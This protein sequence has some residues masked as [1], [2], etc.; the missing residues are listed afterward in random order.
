MLINYDHQLQLPITSV[1][2][3]RSDLPGRQTVPPCPWHDLPGDRRFP[4]LSSPDGVR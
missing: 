2:Y 3:S 4:N 1:A